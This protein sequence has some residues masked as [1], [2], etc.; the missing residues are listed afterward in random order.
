[1][2]N[3]AQT[4][5]SCSTLIFYECF[6]KA[7]PP[8]DDHQPHLNPSP[9]GPLCTEDY[10]VD[11]EIDCNKSTGPDDIFAKM[12]KGTAASVAPSLT[13]LFNLLLISGCFQMHGNSPGWFLCPNLL[14]CL[15]PQ[16][17]DRFPSSLSSV[18]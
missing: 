14:M 18:I 17:T 16:I 7:V 6:N 9:V 13:R 2:W 8:L 10:V 5:K 4:K 1:M 3:P 12:L 11:L 15:C